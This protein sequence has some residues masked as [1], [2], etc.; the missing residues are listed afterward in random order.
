MLRDAELAARDYVALVAKGLPTERDINLVTATLRQAQTALV[1]FADPAWAPEGWALLSGTYRNALAAAEPGSGFQ[2]AWARAYASSARAESDLA[3]LAG[4]LEDRDVPPGLR[5]GADL[6]WAVLQALV[7]LGA[8]RPA[9]IEAELDRDRTA[10][11][12]REAALARALVPTAESKAETWRRLVTDHALPNWLQRAMLQGFQHSA[13]VE[14]TRPY[15]A[16]YFEVVADIWA[17]R[18]GDPAQEFALLAY[19][20][21]QVSEE[22]VALSDA[23]LAEPGHPSPLRR[24]VAEGRDGVIRA[25]KARARDTAAS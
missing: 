12:E 4:W 15:A 16:R 17:H 5:I 11:G 20:A 24:L 22:T 23:W 18:D 19:P 25:L 1:M 6:R 14:L 9:E 13:Q 21:Y 7:A 10:A 3:T 8:A 2:L